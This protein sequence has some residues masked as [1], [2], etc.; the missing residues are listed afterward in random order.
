MKYVQ[1]NL[2]NSKLTIKEIG[3]IVFNKSKYEKYDITP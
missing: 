2:T 1:N 3:N